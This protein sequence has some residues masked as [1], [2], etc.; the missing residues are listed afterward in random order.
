MRTGQ[1]TG[2]SGI[3][4]LAL[5]L[6]KALEEEP[7]WIVCGEAVNGRDAVAKT[8]ALKP[9]VLVLDFTMPELNGLE[10]TRQVRAAK[11]QTEVVILTMH[12]SDQLALAVLA[13]GAR[14]YVFKSDAGTMLVVAVRQL[15]QH[16]PYC[17]VKVSP[18]VRDCFLHPGRSPA[19][20]AIPTWC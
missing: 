8:R 18:Q 13:A 7:G 19:Q 5:G 4:P 2:P 17:T 3:T 10:V 9:D 14:G 6:R 11:L 20:P 1:R 16:R 12:E 15:L